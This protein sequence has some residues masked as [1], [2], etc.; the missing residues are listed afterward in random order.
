MTPTHR[1]S[2]LLPLVAVVIAALGAA[3]IGFAAPISSM[4]ERPIGV[5]EPSPDAIA[6]AQARLQEDGYLKRGT[7]TRGQRDSATIAALKLFQEDHFEP[8][9]GEL[10]P[11]TI[12]LLTQHHRVGTGGTP[13]ANQPE[14]VAGSR[15]PTARRSSSSVPQEEERVSLASR[16]SVQEGAASGRQMPETGRYVLP[17]IL[18]G[19]ALVIAGAAL[20]MRRA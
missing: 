17:S 4:A 10:T 9:N 1:S 11:D 6:R 8:P 13:I 3:S 18:A 12:S 2:R 5:G 14:S 15:A 16:T 20:L 7:Y 19:L